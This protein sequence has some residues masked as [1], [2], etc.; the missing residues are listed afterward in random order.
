MVWLGLLALVLSGCADIPTTGPVVEAERPGGA[1]EISVEVAAE[2]PVAGASPRTVVEGYLQAMATY[3]QGYAIARLYLASDVR[4]SWRPD[5]GVMV[6]ED[7]YGVTS[8]PESAALE[9]P[10]LGR[11]APEG[12][13]RHS[14]ERLAHD[15]HMVRDVDGEWRIHNPPDGLLISSYLFD[16]FYRSLN[17][18]YYDPGWTTVVPDPIFLPEGNQTPTALWQAL[19]RGPTDWLMPA[20]VTAIPA[21]TRLNVQ[22]AF[23][24]SGNVVE[25]SLDESVAALVDEQRSRMAG[26]VVWTLRQ[27]PEVVGVRFLMN[28]APYAVP[29]AVDGVVGIQAFAWLDPSRTQPGPVSMFGATPDGIVSVIDSAR[30]AQVTPVPGPPGSLPGVDAL[31]VSR[32]ADR[33][34]VVAGDATSLR[35]G[36]LTDEMPPEVMTGTGLLRPQFVR[37]R[38]QEMWTIR[39]GDD[40]GQVAHRIVGD[41]VET[42]Q[43]PAFHDARVETFRISPDGVRVAAVRRTPEGRLELGLARVQR[44]LPDIVIDGWQ[45]IPLADATAGESGQAVDV[46]W[47]GPTTLIVLAGH[48]GR[49]PVKPYR[50]EINAASIDE[51]GQPDNWQAQTVASAPRGAG[52]R[53]LVVGRSGTWRYEADYR[54][55]LLTRG[56]V[57]AAYAG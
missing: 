35:L 21:E 29:E 49:H 2:E 10:L 36:P 48:D 9:A 8:T 4:D 56:L 33:I 27:I 46:G 15:F 32:A 43:A 54:W 12:A 44:S 28:G 13:F 41:S 55:P 26:Q 47:L 18:Y 1:P 23:V 11:V 38:E 20:V 5:D 14:S 3:Q 7:G 22:S 51:I 24:D 6:Y 31:A 34:A 57:A 52:G 53:A 19:L 17:V 45:S 42:V 40:G 50:V 39:D 25:V 16:T 37:G 30:G